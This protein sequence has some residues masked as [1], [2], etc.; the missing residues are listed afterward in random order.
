MRRGMPSGDI[1]AGAEYVPFVTSMD[2]DGERLVQVGDEEEVVVFVWGVEKPYV[3]TEDGD[4]LSGDMPDTEEESFVGFADGD[5]DRFV[6]LGNKGSVVESV[7]GMTKSLKGDI[8]LGPD[9]SSVSP[10]LGAGEGSFVAL[11]DSDKERSIHVFDDNDGEL[12]VAWSAKSSYIGST[13]GDIPSGAIICGAGEK[14]FIGSGEDAGENNGLLNFVC[15]VG[16]SRGNSENGDDAWGEEE[17]SFIGAENDKFV[18][19]GENDRTPRYGRGMEESQ[20][21]SE[22][23]DTLGVISAGEHKGIMWYMKRP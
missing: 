8:I 20:I 12:E 17:E 14:L 11:V 13:Y 7:C 10:T 5:M 15:A 19:G 9:K 1:T 4:M 18:D 2:G 6:Q 23:G 21:D 16:D 22:N 3:D